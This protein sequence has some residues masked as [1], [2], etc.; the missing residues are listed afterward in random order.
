MDSYTCS[1]IHKTQMYK[2]N[3]S[4]FEYLIIAWRSHLVNLIGSRKNTPQDA[5]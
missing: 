2:I 3:G 1:V 4:P 5:L